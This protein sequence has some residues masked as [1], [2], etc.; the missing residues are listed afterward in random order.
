MN[1][2]FQFNNGHLGTLTEAAASVLEARG[3]G[4]IVKDASDELKFEDDAKGKPEKA[5]KK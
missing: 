5:G 1:V 2:K 3:Q 4:A